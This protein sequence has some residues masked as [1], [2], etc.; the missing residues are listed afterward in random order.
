MVLHLSANKWNTVDLNALAQRA[1]LVC[2]VAALSY[3]SARVAGA[4]VPQRAISPWVGGEV[5]LMGEMDHSAPS[6]DRHSWNA[7]PGV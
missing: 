7:E 6:S 4:M 1:M 2:A 3:L 5:S